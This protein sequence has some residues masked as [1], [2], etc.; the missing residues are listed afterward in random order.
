VVAGLGFILL[1][2]QTQSLV[3]QSIN[4]DQA[5]SLGMSVEEMRAYNNELDLINIMADEM[6]HQIAELQQSELNTKEEKLKF[7]SDLKD[8]YD[9]L[10]A[11]LGVSPEAGRALVKVSSH[12]LKAK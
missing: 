5:H 1:D 2:N 7:V 9:L 12:S 3:Y 8:R 11:N 10:S 6:N 4:E